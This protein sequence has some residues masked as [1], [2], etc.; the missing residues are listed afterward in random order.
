MTTTKQ[1]VRAARYACGHLSAMLTAL[2]ELLAMVRNI[3]NLGERA[4]TALEHPLRPIAD[5]AALASFN[6]LT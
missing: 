2:P 4:Q 3:R 5:M 6:G 1:I